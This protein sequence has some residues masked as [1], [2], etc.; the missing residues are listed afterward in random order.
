MNRKTE[1]LHIKLS[2]S[3]MGAIRDAAEEKDKT[4][5]AVVEDLID[6]YLKKPNPKIAT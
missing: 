4:I 2:E 3:R 5:T 1:T 6:N